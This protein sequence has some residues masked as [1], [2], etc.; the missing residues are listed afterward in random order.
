MP[1]KKLLLTFIFIEKPVNKPVLWIKETF[2][3]KIGH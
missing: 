2:I 1:V 3:L